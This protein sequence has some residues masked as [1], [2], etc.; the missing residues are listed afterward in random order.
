MRERDVLSS[1]TTKGL[2]EDDVINRKNYHLLWWG[3]R[4]N[5]SQVLTEFF[6]LSLTFLLCNNSYITKIIPGE[7]TRMKKYME[8][9]LDHKNALSSVVWLGNKFKYLTDSPLEVAIISLTQELMGEICS[10]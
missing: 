9:G 1:N 3:K 10:V 8:L 7:S 6:L 2:K 4:K 5:C